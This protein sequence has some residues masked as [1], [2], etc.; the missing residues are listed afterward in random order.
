MTESAGSVPRFAPHTHP[1]K[2]P[3]AC[4]AGPALIT[5]NT[6]LRADRAKLAWGSR[7]RWTVQAFVCAFAN[8]HD[9]AVEMTMDAAV[10]ACSRGAQHA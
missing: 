7:A 10:R 3:P 8:A 1:P 9:G 6:A 4:G 5:A 2:Q